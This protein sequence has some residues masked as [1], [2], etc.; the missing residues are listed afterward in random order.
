[1]LKFGHPPFIAGNIINLYN[2][3][4]ND[5][6]VFPYVIDQGLTN[7]LEGMLQKDPSMRFTLSQVTEFISKK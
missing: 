7:I 4:Q 3:I 6:L 2:K 1:M 5:P